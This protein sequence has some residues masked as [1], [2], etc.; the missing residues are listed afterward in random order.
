VLRQ[1]DVELVMTRVRDDTVR[2]LL[3]A[4]GLVA[5]RPEEDDGFSYCRAFPTLDEGEQYAED[6]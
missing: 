4:H 2:R 6:R 3:V 1:L 5:P